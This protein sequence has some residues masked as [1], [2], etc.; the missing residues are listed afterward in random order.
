NPNGSSY[1]Y[2]DE[3][4]LSGTSFYRLSQSDISG[5][6][7]I[8]DTKTVTISNTYT[9][10]LELYPNP[11]KENITVRLNDSFA[12]KLQVR[13]TSNSGQLLKTFD[14]TK[15]DGRL[16]QNINV[17]DIPAGN[18]ILEIKGKGISY[19]GLFIKQ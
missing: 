10:K 15:S 4:P 17:T 3:S 7:E 8:F 11:A 14:L 13:I 1:Q 19:S 2:I 6:T 18:Y 9:N 16:Q 5:K 12:G